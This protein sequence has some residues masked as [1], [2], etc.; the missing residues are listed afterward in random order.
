VAADGKLTQLGMTSLTTSIADNG[1]NIVLSGKGAVGFTLV[2]TAS[3]GRELVAFSLNDG[4]VVGRLGV[5]PFSTVS[6]TLEMVETA[7]NKRVLGF[8]GDQSTLLLVDAANPATMTLL[9]SAAL[10][11]NNEFS[12][13]SAM[14][15]AFSADARYV[16]V[17][18]TFTDFSAVDVT[19]RQVVDS[20]GGNFRSSPAPGSSRTARRGCW[21]SRA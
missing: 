21:P 17:G 14:G 20:V 5:T 7:D 2:A 12:T 15:I 4:A 13:L 19:T 6:E 8:M 18:N 9:G 1:S 11:R 16:F 10:P 3:S